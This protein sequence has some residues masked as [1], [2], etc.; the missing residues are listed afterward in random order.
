MIQYLLSR[1]YFSVHRGKFWIPRTNVI[2]HKVVLHARYFY[3]NPST[4]R[5]TKTKATTM[6]NKEINS[7]TVDELSLSPSEISTSSMSSTSSWGSMKGTLTGVLKKKKKKNVEKK[8]TRQR[9]MGDE[10]GNGEFLLLSSL[11]SSPVNTNTY[12][13]LAWR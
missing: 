3:T 9:D 4:S 13:E 5:S 11:M 2:S 10:M 7:K 6:A 1:R 12:Q 8:K